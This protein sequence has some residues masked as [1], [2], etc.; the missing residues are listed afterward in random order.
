[1][2]SGDGILP[3][4][5]N[6][7]NNHQNHSNNNSNAAS[8]ASAA[9]ASRLMPPPHGRGRGNGGRGRGRPAGR[10][11]RGGGKRGPGRPPNSDRQGPPSSSSSSSGRTSEVRRGP[12]RPPGKRKK[13][14]HAGSSAA[15]SSSS[16]A[17][18]A[19]RK[20]TKRKPTATVESDE[21]EDDED[22]DDVPM[23]SSTAMDYTLESKASGYETDPE[24]TLDVSEGKVS[25]V[26]WD[27]TEASKVGW[28]VRLLTGA[29][30][31]DGR[32]V[33]YDPYTH[34]HKIVLDNGLD[35]DPF[36]ALV[37][38]EKKKRKHQK[39]KST[40]LR[41]PHSDAQVATRLV[42]AHVKGYAWWPAMEMEL[43]SPV[44][45]SM[46]SPRDG[47]VFVHFIGAPEVATLRNSPDC[48][49][50]FSQLVKDPVIEKSKKKRNAKAIAQAQLEEL[51][52]QH[53]K[54]QAA[55][56]LAR[57]ALFMADHPAAGSGGARYVGKR[58]KLFSSDIN[59][60]DGATVLGIVRQYSSFQKKW[61]VSFEVPH[62][63]KHKMSAAWINLQSKDCSLTVLQNDSDKKGRKT[64]IVDPTDID[65][66]PYL[67][68][69]D[70]KISKKPE[71]PV[72]KKKVKGKDEDD[73]TK[74]A[75][76]SEKDDVELQLVAD[77]ELAKVLQERCRGCVDIW[78]GDKTVTC[79]D[80]K[81]FY[82]LGCVDPP[83]SK[84]AF[85][86]MPRDAQGNIEG[87][88][89]PKCTLCL[90]CYQKDIAFGAHPVHPTP[91]TVSLPPG[92]T[93]NLC[94]MC[95]KAYDAE[96]YCPNCAHSWDDIKYQKIVEQL[97]EEGVGPPEPVK[98]RRKIDDD[99]SSSDVSDSVPS[100]SKGMPPDTPFAN[101]I[102]MNGARV[103]P[104]WYHAENNVWGYSEGDMLVCDSCDL[105]IHAGCGG[106]NQDEYEETS[107]GNHPIYSK[108]FLCRV[109]CRKR[110]IELIDKL[111]RD[112]H[113][114]L[115]AVPVTEKVAPNY[116]DVI[117][118]PM[119]LQTM[120]A[121]A[122]KQEYL[123]YAWVRDDFALMVFN[124]LSFNRFYTKFWYEAKRYYEE[125]LKV[126]FSPKTLGKAAPPGKYDE[127]VQKNFIAAEA[128]RKN[129]E[130]RIQQDDTTEK[131]DLVGGAEVAMVV[132]APLREKAP[133]ESSCLPFQLVRVKPLDSY[134]VAW[135][136]CC[137]TCGSSGAADTMIFC[138]DCGE[139]FHSF[140]ANVPIHSMDAYSV[141][142]W[143]CPNCKIC[144]IS[145]DV[146]ADELRMLFC[147]MCDRAFS[148]DLL[149]PPLRSAPSGLWICG[150]CV[151]CKVCKNTSE[152]P[153][154]GARLNPA[155]SNVSLKYWSRD[156]EKC[157]RCGGC[158]GMPKGMLVGEK[159]DCLVCKKV[160]RNNDGD[161]IKCGD[162][163]AHVHIGCDRRADDYVKQLRTE[164]LLGARALKNQKTKVSC[165]LL[166]N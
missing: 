80:C 33:Q 90:G 124:A 1:M 3:P 106:L 71:P 138:V 35:E 77:A 54:N 68:G 51:Q 81:G 97:E 156:P 75:A 104:A 37:A 76:I 42:W 82:H 147:E 50:L 164:E 55:R 23:D 49:R 44:T 9:E 139:A 24:T 39:S 112:D 58:I 144:E 57:K 69:F 29:T 117:K 154:P 118:H 43:T 19:K 113:M 146:P 17:P 121:K 136:D 133:D 84:Q 89:C 142:G 87:W 91:P 14:A 107:E 31:Q 20:Y 13:L 66:V 119:D 111:Q 38:L 123:N 41:L 85:Q 140:C 86:R 128:A 8:D 143:R 95:V 27:P 157:Y 48:I 152:P 135:M 78:S 155:A 72:P 148:L 109:C 73:A 151:D 62:K 60:P 16:V 36:E 126:V 64:D 18:K 131:K 70:Y 26:H 98:Q 74:P 127:L 65:F 110:C 125:C 6:P 88:K 79:A 22:D 40:W 122:K 94:S 46:A 134:Y 141:A 145:G 105:W 63:L 7:H 100:I 129:E 158:D 96:K 160:L 52:L 83:I 108:E 2:S 130:E 166:V 120:L 21:E 93:L 5:A 161:F 25:T 56:H 28:K 115:F 116:S 150:Q 12:G 101:G 102:L 132:L 114:M 11:G 47:Y 32:I 153:R 30:V 163:K 165:S 162:C 53:Y 137:F 10:G 99:G 34:K 59:Y 61:L 4:P 92:E 103:D 159:L 149:D 45:S 15:K 67:F